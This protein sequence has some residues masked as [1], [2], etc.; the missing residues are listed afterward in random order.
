MNRIAVT[1]CVALGTFGVL[2]AAL[3]GAQAAGK[4]AS[5]QNERYLV[6]TLATPTLDQE[7][8][9][10]LSDPGLNNVIT[11]RFSSLLNPR[12]FIDPQNVVNQLTPKVEFLDS[13]FARLPGTPSVRRNVFTFSPLSPATPVL[14]QGQYTLNIKSSVRNTRGRLLNEGASDFTTSFT[15]GTDVYPPVLRKISPIN[16]QSGIGLFQ[17]VTA[18]FNEPIDFASAVA[19]VIVQDATTSPPT[20]IAGTYS[21]RRSGFD[22]EFKPDP[23]FGYPPKTTIQFVIQGVGYNFSTTPPTPLA[24]S[25][26]TDL[27]QNK[28]ARDNG[29]QW[30]ADPILAHVYNSPAGTYD[31]NAGTFTMSFVT[32][33]IKPP[34][35]GLRPGGPQMGYP[36]I[37]TPC[38]A[39]L[40]Y[41]PDCYAAG[42]N[43]VYTTTS[44]LGE[45]DLRG[46]INSFNAGIGDFTAISIL[47]NTPVRLGRPAGIVFDPRVIAPIANP[48]PPPALLI[49]STTFHT[50]IYMVDERTATVAIVRSD[51]FKILGRI[52]GFSSPKDVSITNDFGLSRTAL[53]VS[54]FAAKA[55]VA[56]DLETIKVSFTG[57]PGAASPCQAIKDNQSGRAV[58]TV[59]AG[60]SE[61]VA[62]G[63][64]YSRVMVCNTLDNSV[65]IIDP[66]RAKVLNNYQ[67]GSNPISCD[68]VTF[69]FGTFRF[70]M[71]ANQGGL[72]DPDGSASLYVNTP[73]LSS[74]YFNGLNQIRDGIENTFTD[75][76]KNPTHVFGNSRWYDGSA[77]SAP[78]TFEL[79]N[80]GG[81]TVLDFS[82]GTQGSVFGLS[83]VPTVFN[84]VDVGPNPSSSVLDAFYPMA[85]QFTSVLGLGEVVGNDP[86]RYVAPKGIQVPGCRR[87]YNCM[88]N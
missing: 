8:L 2:S 1:A 49:D 53:Y 52:T 58:I 77:S 62:D 12:D 24:K 64:L 20:P 45:I 83:V 87:L 37:A 81:H 50:F 68:W 23:C 54:D 59:G 42:N 76:V 5:I 66:K 31:E 15:V 22:I 73:P 72:V 10:D 46:Y 40:F 6:V 35:V 36:P 34:P 47:P 4:L 26:L 39:P 9:P 38:S 57:Q 3:S 14:P 30:T 44:G 69:Q 60:P 70:A 28:F 82:I 32:I 55:V 48:N 27:F 63:L 74:V 84:T 86:A 78:A 79:S 43:F 61:V 33:G 56:V 75:N 21:L 7:V 80:T 51:N 67:V 71:I 17:S 41:A 13:T 16:G 18:T 88:T 25:A 65:S 19:S 11:V 29:F 85:L